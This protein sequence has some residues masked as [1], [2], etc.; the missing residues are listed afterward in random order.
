NRAT[1]QAI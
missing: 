1:L